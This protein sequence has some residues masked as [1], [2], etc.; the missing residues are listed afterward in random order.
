MELSIAQHAQAPAISSAPMRR[1]VLA[2]HARTTPPAT[3]A[4]VPVTTRR[5]RCSPNSKPASTTV[6]PNSRFSS[7][8]ALAAEVRVSPAASNTGAM[9]PPTTTATASR[10]P[11][12][13]NVGADGGSRTTIG[14]TAMA[15][16]R[17]SRP[18]RVK[19]L[20]S[21]ASRDAA[22]ADA[23]NST[24]AA[25]Q[26]STPRLFMIHVVPLSCVASRRVEKVNDF[27]SVYT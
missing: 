2:D 15:A 17:Y 6:K 12:R 10:L 4:S 16:P 20:M 26:S 14:M 5:P 9:A 27:L 24:A 11:P 13:R 3:T 18:A 8:D 22:G 21:S 1:S 7:S 23:P 19:A 25:V